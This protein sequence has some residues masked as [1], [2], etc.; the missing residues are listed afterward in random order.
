MK[1]VKHGGGSTMVWD[2]FSWRGEGP[3]VR[4]EGIMEQYK[5]MERKM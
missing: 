4:I 5:G 3:I 1:T 2:A